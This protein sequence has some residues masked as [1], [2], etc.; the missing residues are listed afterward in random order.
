M[1]KAAARWV[2]SGRVQG[3]WYRASTREKA[4]PLG[5]AGWVRNL[6]DGGVEVFA[7]GPKAKVEELIA[8]CRQGPSFADVRSVEVTWTEPENLDGFQVRY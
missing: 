5:L 1:E 3:V 4:L 8:W 2:V 7:E 6:P